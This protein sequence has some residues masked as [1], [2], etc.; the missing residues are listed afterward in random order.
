MRNYTLNCIAA[1]IFTLI[2]SLFTQNI[3]AQ[4]NPMLGMYYQNR[5]LVNPAYAG[6]KEDLTVNLAYKRDWTKVEGTPSSNNV[7]ADYGFGKMGVGLSFNG[8]KDGLIDIYRYYATYAYHL[9]TG[10]SSSLSLGLSGGVTTEN[11]NYGNLIGDGDDNEVAIYNDKGAQLDGDFGMYYTVKNFTLQGVLPN[12]RN[13]FNKDTQDGRVYTPTKFYSALSYKYKFDTNSLEPMVTYRG[14]ENY[15]NIIDAGLNASFL[16]DQFNLMGIYHS[17]KNVSLGLG[18]EIQ[19]KYQLQLAYTS[20]LSG[21]LRKYSAGSVQVGFR[22][23]L[24]TK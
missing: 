18:F 1:G 24:S 12:L 6:E 5:Y 4:V 9:T 19:K 20:P 17:T 11:I 23:H 2:T 22:L 8:D 21:T 13:F 14:V 10:E 3:S 16:D 7:T 15:E